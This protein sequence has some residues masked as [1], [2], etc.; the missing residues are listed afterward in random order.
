MPTR[1]TPKLENRKPL[2]IEVSA[3]GKRGANSLVSETRIKP[4]EAKVFQNLM[5]IEDGVPYTRWGTK[6]YGDTLTETIDGFTEYVKTD[7]TREL[8]VVDNGTVKKSTDGTSWST[9]TGTTLTGGNKCDFEQVA[10]FDQVSGTYKNYLYIVNGEDNLIRY[11][12]STLETYT[13]RSAPAWAG[14]PIAKTGLS[15]TTYTYYYQVWAVTAVG[16]TLPSTEESITVGSLRDDWDD[17]NYVTLDWD[18]VTDAE[19]YIVAVSDLSGHEV[20]LDETT[21][22]SYVDKGVA[23]PNGFIE[24]PIDNTTAG[25]VL[26]SI[27]YSGGRLWG[28][29]PSNQAYFTGS[30]GAERGSFGIHSGGGWVAISRGSRAN[31][32]KIV[33]FQ[34]KPHILFSYPEGGGQVWEINETTVT[35]GG[36]DVTVMLPKKIVDGTGTA[37][38]YGVV[39]VENDIFYFDNGIRVL[40]NEPGVLNV[41]RTNELSSKVRPYIQSLRQ[42]G[43][44][45]IASYYYDGKVFFS[46]PYSS[47]TPDRIIV[48]DRERLAWYVDWTTGVSQFGVY[49]DN[50]D[51]VHFLGSVGNK[52]VEFDASTSGDLGQAFTVTYTGPRIPIGDDDFS[53]FAKIQKAFA[54]LRKT[55]GNITITVAGTGKSEAYSNLATADITPESGQTGVSFEQLSYMQLS[56]SSG[57]PTTFQSESLI[58]EIRINKLIRDIQL[59]V[60]TTGL[61]DRFAL[62]G[63]IF[64]GIPVPTGTPS[65]WRT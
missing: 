34:G 31:M 5:L 4:E 61:T 8:I 36:V 6:Q 27:A 7:G 11:N 14:T 17:S 59:T 22:T 48:Y 21:G 32:A 46:V 49:T 24:P 23:T 12:G 58:K 30:S 39:H 2:V 44:G 38:P 29:G 18:A 40:G 51:V 20:Y 50:D 26:S 64:K 47:D 53:Q 63:Y 35:V 62:T 37:S 15:G 28:V 42:S 3:P 33:D 60:Q 41:L 10:I 43:Y 55:S 13:E 65:S 45:N 19:K 56:N 52:L 1:N 57:T 25:P 54:R 16:E 9:I